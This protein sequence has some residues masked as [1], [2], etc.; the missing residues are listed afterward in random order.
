MPT[1]NRRPLLTAAAII[2]MTGAFGA[3]R[4]TAA[5]SYS[6]EK[7]HTEIIFSYDHLGNSR[8]Y[9]EF[10]SF[11]GEVVLDRDDPSQSTMTI[12]IDPTG[13]DTGV[14]AFDTH[15]MSADFF[16]VETF[17]EITFVSTA[18]E[19]TGDT[20]ARVTGDLTIKDNTH[21][22][23]LDVTL[24]YIGEHQLAEF[25]PDYAGMEVAGFSASGTL[26]RSAFGLGM[27]APMVGD[28]VEL[29]IET[30]LLRPMDL[31]D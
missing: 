13:I 16:D 20:T 18:V 5:D 26:N 1:R 21:P 14:E 7:I 3:D 6:L 8:A 10:R 19:P 31:V 23:V 15:L 29:I 9:G 27:M 2:A 24:N 12:T 4:A 25:V 11:D 17:P 22:V 30:E 28:E